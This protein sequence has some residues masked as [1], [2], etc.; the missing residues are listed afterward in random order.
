MHLIVLAGLPGTGK[1]TLARALSERLGAPVLDKDRVREALFGPAFVE[2]TRAQDDHCVEVLLATARWLAGSGR[3]VALLD[4]RTF[5]REGDDVRIRELA[6]RES[7]DLFWVECTCEPEVALARIAADAGDHPAA[8]R[9]AGL[10]RR[11]AA[12]A[13][14]LPPPKLTVR[15]DV[16]PTADSVARVVAALGPAYST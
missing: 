11:L 5:V 9:D 14:P 15:T 16:E 10:Y 2:Y 8:N 3:S 12:E 4:G 1:S 7:L 13:R 6:E